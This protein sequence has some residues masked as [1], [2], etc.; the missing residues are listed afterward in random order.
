MLQRARCKPA[1]VVNDPLEEARKW[2]ITIWPVEKTLSWLDGLAI[3]ALSQKK[4]VKVFELK[5]PYI[6]FEAFDRYVVLNYVF[7]K[8]L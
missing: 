3:K 2:G 6:K 7:I 1:V 4:S 5:A 8:I